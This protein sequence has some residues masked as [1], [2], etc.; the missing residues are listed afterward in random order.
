MLGDA[1]GA[2]AQH[3][4]VTLASRLQYSKKLSSISVKAPRTLSAAFDT[5]PE[6]FSPSCWSCDPPPSAFTHSRSYQAKETDTLCR[7]C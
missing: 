5:A 6:A 3:K 1:L 4:E 7:R 2:E